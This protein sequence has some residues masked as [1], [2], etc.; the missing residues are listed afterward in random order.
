MVELST[1]T[2]DV[3]K[4]FSFFLLTSLELHESTFSNDFFLEL[5]SYDLGL[6]TLLWCMH[7]HLPTMFE[8]QCWQHC[9]HRP[10]QHCHRPRYTSWNCVEDDV[11]MRVCFVE[12]NIM[13]VTFSIKHHVL[14][15]TMNDLVISDILSVF[16]Q[17]VMVPQPSLML[18]TDLVEAH[19]NN[20]A[21]YSWY[22]CWLRGYTMFSNVFA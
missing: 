5:R 22:C 15:M 19:S 4:H 7:H 18:Q 20:D 8:W 6:S 17:M 12:F 3:A 1:W 16:S 11:D 21:L 9:L 10:Q 2:S 13:F 14:T